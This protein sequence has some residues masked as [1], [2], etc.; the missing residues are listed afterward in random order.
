MRLQ[1][2]P[3]R[4][5]REQVLEVQGLARQKAKVGRRHEDQ[6]ATKQ[7]PSHNS[8]H[9]EGQ[10]V[11]SE[12]RSANRRR[13]AQCSPTPRSPGLP[14][15]PEYLHSRTFPLVPRFNLSCHTSAITARWL[16]YKMSCPD[17]HTAA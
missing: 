5:R 11:D 13:L 17:S 12:L 15:L 8:K 9:G 6:V 14:T 10:P 1:G 2:H 16:L 3:G 7:R 4:G